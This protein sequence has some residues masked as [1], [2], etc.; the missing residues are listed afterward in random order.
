[1]AEALERSYAYVEAGADALLIHSRSS[2]PQEI[3]EFVGQ[4]ASPVPL[5]IVPT[6][7][8][9]FTE[10]AIRRFPAIRMVIYANP[11]IR[12]VMASVQATLQEIRLSGGIHTV[13]PRL[14]P[15]EEVFRLQGADA[16]A[17]WEERY[18]LPEERAG[19]SAPEKAPA[20]DGASALDP[21]G[22]AARA[23][24]AKAFP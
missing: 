15:L 9:S 13:S 21:A 8:P 7:Y 5:V 22:L 6:A 10:E 24:R 2:T 23:S 17:A 11:V 20:R 18:G 3:T 1:M 12:T 4:W 14:V 19:A 16:L